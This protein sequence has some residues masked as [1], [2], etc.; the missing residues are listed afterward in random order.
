MHVTAVASARNEEFVRGLGADDFI[1]YTSQPFEQFAQ[2][3]DVVFDTVGGDTFERAFKTLKKGGFMVTAVAF[4]TNEAER[5][6]VNVARAMTAPNA[7]EL[8]SIK[9][10]VEAGKVTPYVDTVLPLTEV[11]QALELSEAGRTRGKIVLSIAI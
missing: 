11:R 5:H 9:E 10:L 8:T 6:G 1:D 4:P 2:D 7:Q 3:M